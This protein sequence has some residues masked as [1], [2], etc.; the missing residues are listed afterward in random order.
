MP[1]IYSS[2]L[3]ELYRNTC[4]I[5]SSIVSSI[6]PSGY[7]LV[8]DGNGATDWQ[9]LNSDAIAAD[10][11]NIAFVTSSMSTFISIL[12]VGTIQFPD[13]KFSDLYT[14]KTDA[15]YLAAYS[16]SINTLSTNSL[17][18]N[19]LQT[20][21]ATVEQ[22]FTSTLSVSTLYSELADFQEI[23]TN[24]IITT[25]LLGNNVNTS[26]I[27]T[28]SLFLTNYQGEQL[29]GATITI[30]KSFITDALST[31]TL[32]TSQI[33]ADQISTQNINISSINGAEFPFKNAQIGM[34]VTTTNTDVKFSTFTST[35]IANTLNTRLAKINQLNLSSLQTRF[36]STTTLDTTILNASAILNSTISTTNLFTSTALISSGLLSSIETGNF[37]FNTLETSS[38]LLTSISSGHLTSL[39]TSIQTALL[40]NLTTEQLDAKKITADLLNTPSVNISTF[41]ADAISSLQVNTYYISSVSAFSGDHT[42]SSLV[43]YSLS[44]QQLYANTVSTGIIDAY[45]ISTIFASSLTQTA[46]QVSTSGI[47]YTLNYIGG[48]V[49]IQS[50]IVSSV[51]TS[52]ILLKEGSFDTLNTNY[53]SSTNTSASALTTASI[54]GDYLSSQQISTQFFLGSSL[55]AEHIST[56]FLNTDEIY[57]NSAEISSLQANYL[58]T[59]SFSV[60]TLSTNTTAFVSTSTVLLDTEILRTQELS[61]IF[62]STNILLLS[63]LETNFVSTVFLN[64]S[65]GSFSSLFQPNIVTQ[66]LETDFATLSSL[67]IQQTLQSSS[68]IIENLSSVQTVSD[69]MIISELF[70]SSINGAE[71]PPIFGVN[72][73]LVTEFLTVGHFVSSVS[74]FANTLSTPELVISNADIG[75]LA[76]NTFSTSFASLKSSE[77]SSLTATEISS[78]TAFAANL[79][80]S[81]LTIQNLSSGAIFTDSVFFSTLAAN[82]VSTLEL[83]APSTTIQSV[84]A[85]NWVSTYTA[86]S[87]AVT[88]NSATLSSISASI[89]FGNIS[90]DSMMVN[91]LSTLGLEG[92]NVKT[93]NLTVNYLSTQKLS[94]STLEGSSLNASTII[95]TAA[96]LNTAGIDTLIAN[97]ISTSVLDADSVTTLSSFTYHL[98]SGSSIVNSATVKEIAYLETVSATSQETFLT[99]S[100]QVNAST[101]RAKEM[102]TT[103]ATVGSTFTSSIVLLEGSLAAQVLE[104]SSL[105]AN[106]ISSSVEISAETLSLQHLSTTFI[107]SGSFVGSNAQVSTVNASYL[108]SGQISTD[109]ISTLLLNTNHLSTI[110]FDSLAISANQ[111][112]VGDLYA[113]STFVNFISTKHVD[114]FCISTYSELVWGTNT[115]IVQGSSIFTS[116]FV[117][118][119]GLSVVKVDDLVVNSLIVDNTFPASNVNVPY[120]NTNL[121]ST[122]TT[123]NYALTTSTIVTNT[124]SSFALNAPTSF[125]TMQQVYADFI[126]APLVS[127]GHFSGSSLIADAIFGI[128]SMEFVS[129]ISTLSFVTGTAYV[130]SA[131]MDS[132]STNSITAEISFQDSLSTNSISTNAIEAGKFVLNSLSTNQFTAEKVTAL[133]IV[134]SVLSTNHISTGTLYASSLFGKQFATEL[135]STTNSLQGS[136]QLSVKDHANVQ[137]ISTG[138]VEAIASLAE[139]ISTVHVSVKN[140]QA[141]LLEANVINTSILTVNDIDQDELAINNLYSS[142]I[143]TTFF[144]G[145]E[146]RWDVSTLYASSLTGI[147]LDGKYAEIDR[148]VTIDKS[149]EITSAT[150]RM[151]S[152]STNFMSVGSLSVNTAFVNLVSTPFLSTGQI[153]GTQF[154]VNST[155]V[156][157]LSSA[158][159]STTRL[160][161][162]AVSTTALSTQTARIQ[163]IVGGNW[164]LQ[165]ISAA[166]IHTSSI[167][168]STLSTSLISSASLE[169]QSLSISSFTAFNLSTSFIF[170]STATFGLLQIANINNIS[171]GT[172]ITSDDLIA[173]NIVANTISTNFVQILNPVAISSLTP[174]RFNVNSINSGSTITTS[175]GGNYIST[176]SL[177][178]VTGNNYG[179]QGTFM[180]FSTLQVSSLNIAEISANIV[181]NQYNVQNLSSLRSFLSLSTIASS[182]NVNFLSTPTIEIYQNPI[183]TIVISTT[184]DLYA[185]NFTTSNVLNRNRFDVYSGVTNSTIAISTVAT[186]LYDP[187]IT[188]STPLVVQSTIFTSTVSSNIT[189]KNE[190]F[191]FSIS[192]NTYSADILEGNRVF[193][194]SNLNFST[195]N[196]NGT[197]GLFNSN[198]GSSSDVLYASGVITDTTSFLNTSVPYFTVAGTCNAATSN[199]IR[200]STDGGINWTNGTGTTFASWGG[201][202]AYNGQHWVIVGDNNA[203]IGSIKRS[204]NGI[205]WENNV[206]GGFSVHGHDVTWGNNLWVAVGQHSSSNGTIQRSTDGLN[207]SNA[208]TGGFSIAGTAQYYGGGVGITYANGLFVAVGSNS[209]KQGMVQISR[210]GS[211]WSNVNPGTNFNNTYVFKTVGYGNGIFAAGG[212]GAAIDDNRIET[213]RYS[214]DGSNWLACTGTGLQGGDSAAW[215]VFDLKYVQ[216]LNK[217]LGVGAGWGGGYNCLLSS[218]NGIQWARTA[219]NSNVGNIN[220]AAAVTWNGSSFLASSKVNTTNNQLFYYSTDGDYWTNTNISG[221]AVGLG[222]G[223]NSIVPITSFQPYIKAANTNWYG[224]SNT[225]T[226]NIFLSSPQNVRSNTI[227]SLQNTTAINNTLYINPSTYQV[228]INSFGTSTFT[229]DVNGQINVTTS[230]TYIAGS[231]KD[232][233]GTSDK[234]VKTQIVPADLELCK[235]NLQRIPLVHY[236]FRDDLYPTDRI[237]DKKMLGFLAQD[238]KEAFPSA[239]L[240]RPAY[241]FNDFMF[242][243]PTQIMINQ[244][245][246]TQYAIKNYESQ[247]Q[248][249]TYLSTFITNGAHISTPSI[250]LQS[251]F[252]GYLENV[253]LFPVQLPVF[254]SSITSL[255]STSESLVS[256]IDSLLQLS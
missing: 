87:E 250:E 182:F 69:K 196:V 141:N 112:Y 192:T 132:L 50:L 117:A 16:G 4:Y 97:T 131:E 143:S 12:S 85:A 58:Q 194:S 144:G 240:Q 175:F 235:K 218:T 43:G 156:N 106:Y 95:T 63:T 142:S 215:G 252:S 223:V 90:M 125:L 92:Q 154:G 44:S 79:Q 193:V 137:V 173:Q 170:G 5:P 158:Q 148:I 74:T 38:I 245:G 150:A 199:R 242:L 39:S 62:F 8:T 186:T 208:A 55:T 20:T 157:F 249:M 66:T 197:I 7:P 59:S 99:D 232:W 51:V 164:S 124:I 121:L 206:S 35:V 72:P 139:T 133:L 174:Y 73:N 126:S 88:L 28:T 234:R 159:L 122:G 227:Y 236:K 229:L 146:S 231:S 195:M 22:L 256:D 220:P 183:S 46:N 3:S 172:S 111:A 188:L 96:F 203:A 238:V 185:T 230:N 81:S 221:N 10:N 110:Q 216:T 15:K 130:T 179:I 83:Y 134:G 17:V 49:S 205:F 104:T 11:L 211:N 113:S 168:A 162:D 9:I 202:S 178:N 176:A 209:T 200:Y 138:T 145:S 201:R 77:I 108:S 184:R 165:F 237:N 45:S 115:L 254:T 198:L 214:S 98:S 224:T 24:D 171:T 23:N 116:G 6:V 105:Y 161:T 89:V 226:S 56:S 36:A 180:I 219:I 210:N 21:S 169:G 239:I 1:L 33:V 53:I 101:L 70:V 181:A 18:T 2:K 42:T 41:Y 68:T 80:T 114:A 61:S 76:A 52:T 65:S 93:E 103:S 136:L 228:S 212:T 109:Y 119:Q 86:F 167:T 244:Y 91:N 204:T 129:S 40:S 241:G 255:L 207:W 37:Y 155:F 222:F 107:S 187:F 19:S 82:S 213:L 84:L 71:Y 120:L 190:L 100:Y 128:Q 54:T 78:L 233:L 64:I 31:T 123:Y 243:D 140:V 47:I 32:S 246:V 118:G 160:F 217:W 67:G 57:G 253:S 30:N 191:K 163:T 25:Q 14:N 248:S 127:T 177:S 189:S 153:I 34:D 26:S 149:G 166:Q 27:T 151:Q 225:L 48:D 102:K 251:S 75:T 13:T 152:L 135:L 60:T 147:H 29:D 94:A 247:H